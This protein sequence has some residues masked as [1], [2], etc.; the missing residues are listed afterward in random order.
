MAV[1]NVKR[2]KG[3]DWRYVEMRKQW[4]EKGKGAYYVLAYFMIYFI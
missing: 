2:H 1:Y 4:E 3:E